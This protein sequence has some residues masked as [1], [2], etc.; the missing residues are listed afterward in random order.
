MRCRSAGVKAFNFPSRKSIPSLRFARPDVQIV[1]GFSLATQ[2]KDNLA[3]GVFDGC[4][5]S[6]D[7]PID[8]SDIGAHK[9]HRIVT[10]PRSPLQEIRKW[11]FLA[12]RSRVSETPSPSSPSPPR[13]LSAARAVRRTSSPPRMAARMRSW[14]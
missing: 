6:A 7:H 11:L 3:E 9:I 1:G 13:S 4:K 5:V 8:Y 14:G 12:L 10:A 2:G